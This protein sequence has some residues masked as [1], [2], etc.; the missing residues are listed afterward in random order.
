MTCNHHFVPR[1]VPGTRD[2]QVL[3]CVGCKRTYADVQ[4]S[5]DYEPG[6]ATHPMHTDPLCRVCGQPAR[7]HP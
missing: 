1:R 6:E 2:A 4:A 7:R 3:T 5:H